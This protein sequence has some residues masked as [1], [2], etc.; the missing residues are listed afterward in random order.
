[1]IEKAVR[2]CNKN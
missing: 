1:M 2:N